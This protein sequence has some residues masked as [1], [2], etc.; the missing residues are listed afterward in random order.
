MGTVVAEPDVVALVIVAKVGLGYVPAK[1]PPAGPE[2]EPPPPPL[3]DIEA[4]VML[5]IKP[6]L[7]TV[8]TGT[9]VAEPTVVS[10]NLNGK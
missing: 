7:S 1:S 4:E 2:G 3:L 8:I 10:N 9:S 5:L 6:L